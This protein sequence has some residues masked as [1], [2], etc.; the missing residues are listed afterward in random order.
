M[1]FNTVRIARY[2]FVQVTHIL[3]DQRDYF[4]SQKFIISSYIVH[5]PSVA[6]TKNY[7]HMF[8]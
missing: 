7:I 3:L 6:C 2:Y 1:N 4:G 8:D 5:V